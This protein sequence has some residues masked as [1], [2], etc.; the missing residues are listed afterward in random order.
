MDLVNIYTYVEKRGLAKCSRRAGYIL[1]LK[2]EGREPVTLS[3]IITLEDATNRQAELRTLSAALERMRK[4]A[5]LCI[6]ETSQYVAA[7]YTCQW[8]KEWKENGWMTKHN[9][10]VANVDDWKRLDDLLQV[11]VVKWMLTDHHPYSGWLERVVKNA[12]GCDL[13]EDGTCLKM[14]NG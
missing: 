11:H 8:V 5:R 14:G 13:K 3:H 1:E 9:E 6:Y 4:P 12:S 2:R 7:G 10:P